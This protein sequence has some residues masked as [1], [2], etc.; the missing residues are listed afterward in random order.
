MLFMEIK[1]TEHQK[2][3]L[4]LHHKDRGSKSSIRSKWNTDRSRRP[5]TFN[6]ISR[7]VAPFQKAKLTPE[8][9][10]DV[11]KSHRKSKTNIWVKLHT[12]TLKLIN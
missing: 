5:P 1:R 6:V 10:P 3:E 2:K 4:G 9:L 7:F 12:S 11:V 8:R